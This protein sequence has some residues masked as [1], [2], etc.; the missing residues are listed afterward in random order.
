MDT[1]TDVTTSSELWKI[2]PSQHLQEMYEP[3]TTSLVP[4]A[5]KVKTKA[6]ENSRLDME[7]AESQVA[8]LTKKLDDAINAQKIA[9][10]VLEAANGENRRLTTEASVRDDEILKLKSDLEE[11]LKRKAEVEAIRDSAMAEK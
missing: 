3:S 11:S 5:E 9:S 7:E 8:I 6:Y 2:L 4:P 1:T 10:E